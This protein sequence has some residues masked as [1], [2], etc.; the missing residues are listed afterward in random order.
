MNGR[1][2]AIALVASVVLGQYFIRGFRQELA[3]FDVWYQPWPGMYTTHPIK[4]SLLPRIIPWQS[5]P[6]VDVVVATPADV[7]RCLSEGTFD[8]AFHVASLFCRS[9]PATSS[10]DATGR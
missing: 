5:E 3:V 10:Y 7:A 2:I 8:H 6:G 9:R 1:S 4:E